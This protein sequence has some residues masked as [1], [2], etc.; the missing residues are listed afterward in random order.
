VRAAAAAL[1]EAERLSWEL[2]ART[3]EW[4]PPLLAAFARRQLGRRLANLALTLHASPPEPLHL[5]GARVLELVPLLP[6][7]PGQA[8]RIAALPHAG[9]LR[10]GVSA[11]WD[12]LPDLHDLVLALAASFDEIAAAT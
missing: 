2:L 10:L 4:A 9:A 12:L 3:A 7:P 8:L 1:R 5:L 6:L 11:D